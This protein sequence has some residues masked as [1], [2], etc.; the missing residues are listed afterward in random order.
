MLTIRLTRIGK[1]N[2][3][4]YRLVLTDHNFPVKGKFI[5]ILGSFDPRSEKLEI[6]KE[7]IEYWLKTGCKVSQTVL[8]LLKKQKI[9]G[10]M[11]VLNRKDR[12]QITKKGEEAKKPETLKPASAPA[13]KPEEKKESASA[14][15]PADKEAKPAEQKQAPKKEESKTASVATSVVKPEVKKE[16]P[17]VENKPNAEAPK[18]PEQAK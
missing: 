18:T 8:E 3:P 12:A 1:K 2:Q 17:K 9:A 15:A 7:R 6:K 13:V 11:D 4:K 14:K 16:A 10:K 5:E